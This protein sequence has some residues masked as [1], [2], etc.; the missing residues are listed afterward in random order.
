VPTPE[1]KQETVV[2][3]ESRSGV[4]L[5]GRSGP[6]QRRA[7]VSAEIASPS[8]AAELISVVD[9]PRGS[10]NRDRI[11]YCHINNRGSPLLKGGRK[12]GLKT[13]PQPGPVAVRGL[14]SLEGSAEPAPEDT[15]VK[16]ECLSEATIPKSEG[17]STINF[18][19]LG[20]R[21]EPREPESLDPK[22]KEVLAQ[23]LEHEARNAG[24]PHRIPGT[25]AQSK[26]VPMLLDTGA[27]CSL[28]PYRLFQELKA[29]KPSLT[30]Q[31]TKRALHGVDGTQ[32]RV[33]GIAVIDVEFT[34]RYIL[35]PFTV[36]DM[37]DEVI[38]GMEFLNQNDA[39]WDLGKGELRFREGGTVFTQ[40]LVT[41]PT[42][43]C[44]AQLVK[45]T[46]VPAR[47]QVVVEVRPKR[48]GTF[49]SPGMVSCVGRAVG[50][51]GVVAGRTIVD[52][53][54]TGTCHVLVMNPTEYLADLPAGLTVGML[55]LMMPKRLSIRTQV[56]VGS[57]AWRMSRVAKLVRQGTIPLL[58]VR[59]SRTLVHWTE[60]CCVGKLVML[61]GCMPKHPSQGPLGTVFSLNLTRQI[62]KI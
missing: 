22:D 3:Q 42:L 23:L 50:K 8:Q 46:L 30:L 24:R 11:P 58:H 39:Q 61:L 1:A 32:L 41:G 34:G 16:A 10:S 62:K 40:C 12:A 52:P 43:S 37:V 47:S 15:V 60:Y 36:V 20:F 51:F 49:P 38:L 13:P 28:M 7:P 21:S 44:R 9:V 18:E 19:P 55:A 6:I 25:L 57:Q 17:I 26:V 53:G 5:A 35:V 56:L 29:F 59:L 2:R 27:A 54:E 31:S 33:R 48:R 45:R 4:R 14:G